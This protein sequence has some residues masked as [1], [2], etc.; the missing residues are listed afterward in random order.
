MGKEEGVEYINSEKLSSKDLMTTIPSEFKPS[1]RMSYIFS[2]IFLVV[3]L[4]GF[5]QF[6]LVSFLGGGLE[7]A[8]EIGMPLI[9]FDFDFSDPEKF[10]FE[11]VPLIIDL[12]IYLAIAY[13]ID[14]AI[15]VFFKSSFSKSMKEKDNDAKLYGSK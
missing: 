9:F 15:S 11:M 7:Q 2:I 5:L 10:P 1:T 3:V 6:P 8:I 13:V 14:V 12:L 4:I